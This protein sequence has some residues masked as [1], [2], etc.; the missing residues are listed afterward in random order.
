MPR[1]I[2]L[3]LFFITITIPSYS[4]TNHTTQLS[5]LNQAALEDFRTD[6]PNG[7]ID[8]WLDA[9]DLIDQFNIN[10]SLAAEVLN[11]LGY[12]YYK[13]G[14]YEEAEKYLLKSKDID[15]SRWSV[16]LNLGDLYYKQN[17]CGMYV[18]NYQ[19]VLELNKKYKYRQKLR[20]KI[21]VGKRSTDSI[22]VDQIGT[23]YISN[24]GMESPYPRRIFELKEMSYFFDVENY[25]LNDLR[26]SP[27]FKREAKD[28]SGHILLR[29]ISGHKIYQLNSDIYDMLIYEVEEGKYMPLSLD[30]WCE[31][32]DNKFTQ[33]GNTELLESITY[34]YK[35]EKSATYFVF[36]QKGH[37]IKSF[38]LNDIRD[39]IESLISEEDIS[40]PLCFEDVETRMVHYIHYDFGK[41]FIRYM[42]K[43]ADWPRDQYM[44]GDMNV[45]YSLDEKGNIQIVD[46]QLEDRCDQL[47]HN[48][49]LVS[50]EIINKYSK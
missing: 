21:N 6:K 4:A 25:I 26:I 27:S 41:S 18:E 40:Y 2:V 32:D 31:V 34:K 44:I 35:K 47:I 22:C 23:A 43:G 14:N 29:D 11:N 33:F 30:A 49:D 9:A 20:D 19:K 36:D 5:S 42:I 39:D 45:N 37:L 17:I 50:A 10:S 8:N 13:T 7:A 1:L 3:L 38:E 24:C 12:A 28:I 46:Y 48:K 16:Y 15:G